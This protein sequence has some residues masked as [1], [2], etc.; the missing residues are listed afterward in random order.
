MFGSKAVGARRL[1]GANLWG[2]VCFIE[3][4]S[5]GWSLVGCRAVDTAIGLN[6]GRF[7]LPG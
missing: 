5:T 2:L 7:N 1:V 6:E 4:V 3:W